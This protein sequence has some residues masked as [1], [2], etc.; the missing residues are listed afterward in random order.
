MPKDVDVIVGDELK[1]Y[2][3]ENEEDLKG[4]YYFEGKPYLPKTYLKK[5][6]NALVCP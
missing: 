4:W 2:H 1:H 3:F 6:L 5:E